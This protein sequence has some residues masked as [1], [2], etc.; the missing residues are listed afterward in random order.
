MSV[1][2]DRMK[3]LRDGR[4]DDL[5]DDGLVDDGDDSSLVEWTIYDDDTDEEDEPPRK[6]AAQPKKI[7]TALEDRLYGASVGTVVGYPN[8]MPIAWESAWELRDLDLPDSQ[9]VIARGWVAEHSVRRAAKRREEP[10]DS[11]TFCEEC[12]EKAVENYTKR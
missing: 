11:Q 12:A 3:R 2:S 4:A 7:S 9:Q 6:S 1:F 5:V 10:V 8:L